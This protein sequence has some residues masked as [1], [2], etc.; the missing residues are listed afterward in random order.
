MVEAMYFPCRGSI[1]TMKLAGSYTLFVTSATDSCSWYAFSAAI[2]EVFERLD[3]KFD[4]MF[5]RRAFVFWYVA[6]GMEEG[7]FTEAREDMAALEADYDNI[8]IELPEGGGDEEGGEAGE[9]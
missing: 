2:K 9:F 8:A 4:L 3:R 1:F 7:E 6:E 5:A